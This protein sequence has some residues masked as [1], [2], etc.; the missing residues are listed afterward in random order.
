MSTLR[1]I[2]SQSKK[3]IFTHIT[4]SDFL[5]IQNEIIPSN[6]ELENRKEYDKKLKRVSSMKTINWPDNLNMR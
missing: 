5:R 1:P 4:F 3:N 6:S 2:R